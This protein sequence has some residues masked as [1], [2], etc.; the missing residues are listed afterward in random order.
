MPG[1]ASRFLYLTRHGEASSD[2]SALTAR[3]R[4][5]VRLLGERLRGSPL[6]AIYHGPLPRAEQSARLIGDQLDNV[7]LHATKTAGDFVPYVPEM[8]ELPPASV[9]YL[10]G[11]LE[12][13]PPGER[14]QGMALAREALRQFTGPADDDEPRHELV[15]THNFLIAWLVRAALDAPNWRWLGLNHCNAALTII[16]YAPQRPSSVLIYNDMAHLSEDLRWTGFPP[17]L[18]I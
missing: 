15:V 17:G 2:E 18:H 13:I 8:A 4:R 9:D 5:Q 6:S 16:Q 12:Q 7:P 10:T 1:T 11:R 3:G 14:T